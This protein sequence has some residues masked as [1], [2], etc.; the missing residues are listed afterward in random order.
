MAWR[1][2]GKPLVSAY[3]RGQQRDW[4][5]VKNIRHA[6]AII[7]GWRPRQGR[8]TGT[9]NSLLPSVPDTAASGMPGHV[10]ERG[11]VCDHDGG[12]HDDAPCMVPG[13]RRR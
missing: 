12:S 9:I 6:E 3:H 2:V 8:Q 7:G 5:K 1:V 10:G 11:A 13:C 4:I